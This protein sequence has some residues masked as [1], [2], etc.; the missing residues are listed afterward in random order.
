MVE[1]VTAQTWVDIV[2]PGAMKCQVVGSFV[3]VAPRQPKQQQ[4]TWQT[5]FYERSKSIDSN[6]PQLVAF[7]LVIST[8]NKNHFAKT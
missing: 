3:K 6:S 5:T 4:P 2:S 1:T 8:P 7:P